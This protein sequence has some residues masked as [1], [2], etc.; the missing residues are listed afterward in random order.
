MTEEKRK[1]RFFDLL[2]NDISVFESQKS[3]HLAI[4]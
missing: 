3:S 2:D 4:R 1:K